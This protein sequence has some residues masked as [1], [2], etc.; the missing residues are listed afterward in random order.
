MVSPI[1]PTAFSMRAT[2]DAVMAF[3]ADAVR[4]GDTGLLANPTAGSGFL[5]AAW[6]HTFAGG[7]NIEA[8]RDGFDVV[9]LQLVLK[10]L[11]YY[12]GRLTGYYD[13][14]TQEA[15][16]A[17][18][19]ASGLSADGVVGPQTF[20]QIGRHNPVAA[21]GCRGEFP[22]FAQPRKV[23]SV[24]LH[25]F[26]GQD[27]EGETSLLDRGTICCNVPCPP[28]I[29][30]AAGVA[31]LV[32]NES[33]GRETLAVVGTTLAPPSCYGLQFGQYAFTLT[34]PLSGTVVAQALMS[35]TP[36]PDVF[37]WAGVYSAGTKPLPRGRITIHPTPPGIGH[38]SLPVRRRSPAI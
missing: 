30:S 37:G 26:G 31:S 38:R 12:S 36:G 11:A 35:Q 32:I 29:C 25:R 27:T 4:I 33:T 24:V 22:S 28:H 18:Q 13:A 10:R 19:T 2:A 17:F 15:V 9:F 3:K 34:D 5:D 20:Q 8:G 6:L 7:R 21:Q 16:L 1:L 14:F 23:C